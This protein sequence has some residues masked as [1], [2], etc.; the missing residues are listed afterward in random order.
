MQETW[1]I[2]VWPLGREDPLRKL[3]QPSP[4]FLP[5]ESSGQRSVLG[6]SPWI[7]KVSDLTERLNTHACAMDKGLWLS[8]Q[9]RP[10]V[11]VVLLSRS[12]EGSRPVNLQV[13]VSK[14]LWI[15]MKSACRGGYI[16]SSCGFS[17]LVLLFVHSFK[18][19]K[20]PCLFHWSFIILR[21]VL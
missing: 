18:F 10:L 5:G 16:W 6:Y 11:V 4:V 20:I 15:G 19:L 21:N 7:H 12:L 9:E 3:W 8:Q 13:Q 14:H 2:Q 17:V 1:E